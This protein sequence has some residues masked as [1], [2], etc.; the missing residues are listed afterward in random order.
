ML[1]I[2]KMS[3][4]SKLD[5][6][7]AI[8]ISSLVAA[9]LLGTKITTILGV[10]VS[11]GIFAYPLSFLV[12]DI[13][14]EVMGRERA[15]RFIVAGFIS[16]VL[17]I[18]LTSLS[19]VLPAASRYQYNDEYRLVFGASLRM[20]VASMIAFVLAQIH[21]VWAFH[22]LKSKTKGKLLWL[23]NNLSTIFSQFIDTT[24]F[25]FIA[26][27]GVTPKFTASFIFALIIPYWLFKIAFAIIDTPLV[28]LG[29]KWLK[30]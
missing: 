21:D 18:I 2:G 20:I 14:A 3:Q 19:V 28:Y 7:L 24:V 9:N 8:F 26:F 16:L 29:V 30:K 10:S 1:K 25:M 22:L 4:D 15:K 13:V 11:V 12:T 6:M 17:V 23:R 5:I 27:Y